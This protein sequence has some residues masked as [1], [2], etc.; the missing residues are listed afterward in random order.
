[1]PNIKIVSVGGGGMNV[2]NHMIDSDLTEVYLR[3]VN[4]RRLKVVKKFY[5][6][7]AA[8]RQL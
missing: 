6:H 4:R 7:C 1:M 3:E 2:V 8:R 5:R